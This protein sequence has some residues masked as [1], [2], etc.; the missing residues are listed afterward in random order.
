VP[1]VVAHF[2]GRAESGTENPRSEY[3]LWTSIRVDAAPAHHDHSVAQA[4][5]AV[6]VMAHEHDRPALEGERCDRVVQ[7]APPNE[8]EVGVG[9]VE[10]EQCGSLRDDPGEVNAGPLAAGELGDP[11]VAQRG[12]ALRFDS[13]VDDPGIVGR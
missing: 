4:R 6:D 5:H 10:E 2:D 9:L 7:M 11:A 3:L 8:V 13:G 1:G 12:E